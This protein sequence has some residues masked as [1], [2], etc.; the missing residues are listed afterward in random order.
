MS[1]T[2]PRRAGLASSGLVVA[3]SGTVAFAIMGDSLLYGILPLAAEDLGLLPQQVG[4]LLSANR[5]IRLLSN[6]WLSTLF[7]RF[8][9]YRTFV[10]SAI[11]GVLTTAVYG[12]GWGFL[13]LLMARMAWGISWSGLRQGSYQAIWAG[14]GSAAGRLM[15]LMWGVVRGGSAVSVLL[16]GFLFDRYGYQVTVWS[17]AAIS[18]LAI[19]IALRLSW[20]AGAQIGKPVSQPARNM[21]Q[22]WQEALSDPLQRTVLL[23]G[24]FKLLLNAILIATA[25]LFLAER[26]GD[27]AGGVLLGLEVGALTGIVLATR[28][29]SD[30]FL[31]AVMGALSDRIGRLRLPVLL[32]LL[33][34][35]GL[36]VMLWTTASLSILALLGVL[37]TSTGVNVILDAY[38][39]QLALG[40]AQPELFVGAYTTASDLGSALGPLLAFT[41]VTAVGFA[42]VYGVA[43]LLVLITVLYLVVLDTRAGRRPN[44]QP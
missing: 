3:V 2:V 25:S 8:G 15:G 4:L 18:T 36:A 7:A 13:M 39:N 16:G 29:F 43:A 23:V 12:L 10:V 38:A 6:T 31:G 1:E 32:I 42:P 11:L 41:L 27:Q 37:I 28:W 14:A 22:G 24:F 19:P 17:I 33:L 35:L 20:P 44:P 40:T 9:P 21:L 30:L 5:L 26:F 34:C